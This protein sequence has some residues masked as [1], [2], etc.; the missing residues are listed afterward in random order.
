M[1]IISYSEAKKKK[2]TRYF[3]GKPCQKGH[4]AQRGITNSACIVC[5]TI[6]NRIRLK[7]GKHP[8]SERRRREKEKAQRH[9]NNLKRYCTECG[10]RLDDKYIRRGGIIYCSFVCNEEH[11][12]K[13]KLR[14]K[15]KARKYYKEYYLKK[16]KISK[17]CVDCGTII[18]GTK[19][20][21][22]CKVC[23]SKRARRRTKEL[24]GS[25]A[26][27]RDRAKKYG[28]K[29]E[30]FQ[31]KEIFIRDKWRCQS[32][33]ID[34]PFSLKGTN[35]DNA[36]ELDH[37]VPMANGGSHVR[38]NAQCLCRGCNGWK[39]FQSFPFTIKDI[40]LNAA[41]PS[42]IRGARREFRNLGRGGPESN[43]RLFDLDHPVGG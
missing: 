34:T 43:F 30:Y 6:K 23:N 33:G 21:L 37:I 17:P 18:N 42:R 1:N 24:Y 9:L 14:E 8:V 5:E 32:C 26:K 39:G 25:F 11:E 16:P 19:S 31:T 15:E 2:L 36:P 38:T 7:W 3:T 10:G 22:R 41:K 27:D 40:L 12:K 13:R 28:V 4:I 35:A 20:K 29:Y